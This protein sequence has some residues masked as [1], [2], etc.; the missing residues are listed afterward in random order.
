M[1]MSIAIGLPL[2]L[3]S[4]GFLVKLLVAIHVF[5][6]PQCIWKAI[7][8]DAPIVVSML[9]TSSQCAPPRFFIVHDRRGEALLSRSS[10]G[11]GRGQGRGQG[12]KGAEES[13]VEKRG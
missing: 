4:Q 10:G 6:F 11:R 12:K 9:E 7:L 1:A 2:D 13:G 3:I 8:S 5:M